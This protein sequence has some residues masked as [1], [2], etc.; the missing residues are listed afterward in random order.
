ML[1]YQMLNAVSGQS[2]GFESVQEVDIKEVHY[3]IYSNHLKNEI[4]FPVGIRHSG[5]L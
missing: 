5:N 3:L 1:N 2:C 4:K